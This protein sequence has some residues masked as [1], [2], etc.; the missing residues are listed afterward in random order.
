MF[1][2]LAWQ[3]TAFYELLQSQMRLS[4]ALRSGISDPA[5]ALRFLQPGRLIRVD[6][7]PPN[8]DRQLP[9]L[10]EYT[11][12]AMKDEAAGDV[13]TVD[14]AAGPAGSGSEVISRID[15][16]IWGILVSFE[17]AGK[18][19]AAADGGRL[20]SA[21]QVAV[22]DDEAAGSSRGST[23]PR[24]V[25][26]VL[27]NVDPKTLSAGSSDR[28]RAAE[29]LLP[30]LLPPGAAGGVAVVLSLPLD[31]L[32]AVS[33]VRLKTLKDLRTAAARQTGLA[34]AAEVL[35]RYAAGSASQKAAGS[36]SSGQPPLLDPQQDM[37]VCCVAD[38][39]SLSLIYHARNVIM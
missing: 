36:S 7:C 12:P 27:I 11:P 19:K 13:E 24:F 35:S 38:S 10:G 4:E 21:S 28:V 6:V 39:L 31:H 20:T 30:R 25:M 23:G 17:K 22:S 1:M 15:S 16:S 14:A 9:S 18:H 34:A 8:P 37:Q 26:D 3:V 29:G 2:H 5:A 33:A 32:S